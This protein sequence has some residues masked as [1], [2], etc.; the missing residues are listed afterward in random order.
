[1]QVSFDFWDVWV[2]ISNNWF[3]ILLNP[4]LKWKDLA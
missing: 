4:I 2:E 3:Q 1:M